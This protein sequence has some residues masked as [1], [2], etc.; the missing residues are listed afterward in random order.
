MHEIG[1]L[2]GTLDLAMQTAKAAAARQIVC[3]RLR[4]GAMTGLVPEALQF[5]FEALREGTMASG[6]R[7][8]I[9]IVLPTGWCA[10]CAQE[11]KMSDAL[12]L[13]PRCKSPGARHR[14]GLE[15]ELASVDVE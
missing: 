1:I 12:A 5:A 9:E 11:F 13:C 3:L 4:V 8:E 10:E 7:L 6:A 14:G 15:L 2:Q